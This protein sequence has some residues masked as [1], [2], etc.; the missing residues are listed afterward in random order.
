VRPTHESVRRI[1]T[2]IAAVLPAGV[3]AWAPATSTG[4]RID[5]VGFLVAGLLVGFGLSRLTAWM[6]PPAVLTAAA[7]RHAAR[8]AHPSLAALDR[9][10]EPVAAEAVVADAP[11]EPPVLFDHAREEAAVVTADAP[12]P[13]VEPPALEPVA[14]EP[15]AVEPAAVEPAAVEPAA[16]EP[17]AEAGVPA[18]KVPAKRAKGGKK[19]PRPAVEVAA[20]EPVVTVPAATVEPEVPAE[21]VPAVVS[22]A[23]P[24][25]TAPSASPSTEAV[26]GDATTGP[27]TAEPAEAVDLV[28]L[29]AR[30]LATQ[31]QPGSRD[32]AS[33]FSALDASRVTSPKGVSARQVERPRTPATEATA[34]P[35]RGEAPPTGKRVT[36]RSEPPSD[37]VEAARDE[38]RPEPVADTPEPSVV[39]LLAKRAAANGSSVWSL[40]MAG[41]SGSATWALAP[42]AEAARKAAEDAVREVVDSA[43]RPDADSEPVDRGARPIVG[44][45]PQRDR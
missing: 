33:V 7:A 16:V 22:E 45:I 21:P 34:S 25:A 13:Q 18:A 43:G 37:A 15:A 12:E 9:D 38:R 28:G 29:A 44:R 24:V 32:V 14:V 42:T 30:A 4:Q 40:A 36:V 26:T 31:L 35:A 1:G 17:V 11:V 6:S 23:E 10:A 39:E 5:R 8:T 3:A 20:P 41:S 2:V 27:V 19:K